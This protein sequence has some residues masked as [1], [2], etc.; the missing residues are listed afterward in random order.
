MIFNISSV[1]PDFPVCCLWVFVV[2]FYFPIFFSNKVII[3]K[4][5]NGVSNFEKN[6]F[7]SLQIFTNF[8][9]SK[10][11]KELLGQVH[12]NIA[13]LSLPD[14]LLS[15]SHIESKRIVFSGMTHARLGPQ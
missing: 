8:F 4:E 3:D 9:P 12:P 6:P 11:P 15:P 1:L 7:S 10:Y 5:K 2:V 13:Y 14:L